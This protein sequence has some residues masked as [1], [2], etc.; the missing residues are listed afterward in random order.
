[1]VTRE[2]IIEALRQVQEPELGQDLISLNMV[3]DI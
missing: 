3:R 2:A 1:M